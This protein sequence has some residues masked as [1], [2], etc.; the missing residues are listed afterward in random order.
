MDAQKPC[1][2]LSV[3]TECAVMCCGQ[4]EKLLELDGDFLV[5]ESSNSSNQ[6]VLSG[7]QN[8]SIKHLLLVDPEGIVSKIIL[9][10][11]L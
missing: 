11:M 10:L 5:R 9:L 7:K 4:T 6:F 3:N 1:Y 8:G 2:N